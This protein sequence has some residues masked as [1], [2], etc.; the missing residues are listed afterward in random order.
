MHLEFLAGRNWNSGEVVLLVHLLMGL[1]FSALF[2]AWISNHVRAGL[3]S[4]Q[5][6]LFTWLS[7]LLLG[8]CTLILLS[9]LLMALPAAL[10]LGHV[11]WFWSFETTAVLAFLH[12]WAAILGGLGLLLHLLLRHWR[13][14]EP[15]EKENRP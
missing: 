10:Y 3:F 7:W 6:P 12:L 8:K 14:A 15:I 9:G 4:S 5:R 1:G 13:H 11:I 2:V